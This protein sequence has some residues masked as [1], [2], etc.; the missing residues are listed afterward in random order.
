[1]LWKILQQKMTL[2]HKLNKR[3]LTV[4]LE[5]YLHVTLFQLNQNIS[6]F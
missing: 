2:Y 3:S 4:K 1:M 6:T 5:N